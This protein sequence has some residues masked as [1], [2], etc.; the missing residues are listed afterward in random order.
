MQIYFFQKTVE[1]CFREKQTFSD[2]LI[3]QFDRKRIHKILIVII[4]WAMAAG[5]S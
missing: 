2:F 3:S 5:S 4:E 1:N